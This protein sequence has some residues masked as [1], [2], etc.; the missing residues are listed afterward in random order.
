MTVKGKGKGGRNVEFLLALALSLNKQKN[1]WAISCDTDGIDGYGN[2]AGAYISPSTLLRS[3]K[4]GLDSKSMLEDN[5]AYHFF[6]RLN[7]LIITGPTLTNIN[8]YRAIFIK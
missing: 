7:D 3:N 8:D 4:L 1:V 2:H 6:E 5:N